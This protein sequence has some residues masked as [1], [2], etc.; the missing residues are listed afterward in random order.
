M[1]P[2]PLTNRSIVVTGGT[3]SFGK[4]FVRRALDVGSSRVA[5]FSRD[6]L[7]QSE[8]RAEFND[9]R[10]RMMIG[11]VED[12]PRVTQAL[13]GADIVVHAAAMKQ[14]PAC[15][16]NPWGADDTNTKGS[17][18][19][20]GAAVECG[21]WRAVMLSTDKA[22]APCTMYGFSK[23][24]AER[25]W[26]RSNV[27]AAG[28]RTRLVATRYGNVIGSRGSVIPMWRAAAEAGR[29]ISITDPTMTRYW[30]RMSQA[31]DLVELAI[32]QGRGGEVFIPVIAS[33][34]LATLADAVAP[35]SPHR[36]IGVRDQEKMHELLISEDEA[37]NTYYC[38]DHYRI[39]PNRTW[40]YLPPLDWQ[41][42]PDG[43][44]YRSDTN[45]LQYNA[46]EMRKLI[47]LEGT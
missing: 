16:D 5:V 40:E 33:C 37:R 17:R 32:S 7:K 28:T 15:E 23:A 41:R 35:G 10:L 19:V 22:A 29:S 31:V 39:E 34:S 42:V 2:S 21:V 18:I 3:G 9:S 4:A 26:V 25:M 44:S 1:K 14:V 6:E 12:A 36:I 20:S 43:F 45:P 8:M 13:R 27:Y 30:M 38:D 24:S 47:G 46:A 11:T